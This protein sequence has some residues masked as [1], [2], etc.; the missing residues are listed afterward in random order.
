MIDACNRVFDDLLLRCMD[1][2]ITSTQTNHLNEAQT[3]I[4]SVGTSVSVQYAGLGSRIA[5]WFIDFL[6][7]FGVVG[8]ILALITGQATSS[9]FDLKG[10]SSVLMVVIGFA[11]FFVSEAVFGRTLGKRILKLRVLREDSIKIGFKESIIRNL[12]RLVDMLP[13]LYIMGIVSISTTPKKQRVGDKFAHT[14][15]VKE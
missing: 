7:W 13:I 3:N 15:V 14:I 5:A 4:P 10:F 8:Y 11:Y 2:Y 6:V 1:N 12:S 9:G